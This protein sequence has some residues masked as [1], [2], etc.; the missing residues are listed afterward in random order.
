MPNSL[1]LVLLSLFFLS[2]ARWP[3][4]FSKSSTTDPEHRPLPHRHHHSRDEP[5]EIFATSLQN[6]TNIKEIDN[7]TIDDF[8][9]RERDTICLFIN[10]SISKSNE[11][12]EEFVKMTRFFAKNYYKKSLCFV[13]SSTEKYLLDKYKIVQYPTLI[14][15]LSE[16]E[17]DRFEG[18]FKTKDQI[19]MHFFYMLNY[20]TIIDVKTVREADA[21]L[22]EEAITIVAILTG[23]D[24][25]ILN[26][27][28]NLLLDDENV[29]PRNYPQIMIKGPN[30]KRKLEKVDYLNISEELTDF[31]DIIGVVKNYNNPTIKESFFMKFDLSVSREELQDEK[32]MNKK[33]KIYRDFIK[34]HAKQAEIELITQ[35]SYE[36]VLQKIDSS[37]PTVLFLFDFSFE[38]EFRKLEFFLDETFFFIANDEL[39]RKKL[40]FLYGSDD[41]FS[42]DL[43]RNLLI[44]KPRFPMIIVQESNFTIKKPSIYYIY[45]K[46]W[47]LVEIIRFL[48]TFSTK[49]RKIIVSENPGKNEEIVKIVTAHSFKKEVF[50]AEKDVFLM[51]YHHENELSMNFLSVFEELARKFEKIAFKKFNFAR[52]FISDPQR[53]E[54]NEP[55][56]FLK[57]SLPKLFY[58]KNNRKNEEIRFKERKNKEDLIEFINKMLERGEYVAREE[59]RR[60]IYELKLKYGVKVE[61]L[62]PLISKVVVDLEE[63]KDDL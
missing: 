27:A 24:S 4:N 20:D 43:Q 57:F 48:R 62:P 45:D 51:I 2:L 26:Q 34:K 44:K 59:E 17:A 21:L 6:N 13:N 7:K 39:L 23:E 52:N 61:P 32:K 46:K 63:L 42:Q 30:L 3:P 16:K 31:D 37:K 10:E 58:F 1:L 28:F 50:E 35:D 56:G 53:F 15:F 41:Q 38:K 60:E 55:M 22:E 5:E 11:I 14:F 33:I 19:S 49:A 36:E 25:S 12:A 8:I 54:I 40:N 29:N 18:V 47:D 9:K